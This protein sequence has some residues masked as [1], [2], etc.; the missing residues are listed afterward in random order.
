MAFGRLLVPVF[1]VVAGMGVVNAPR[2]SV[3]WTHAVADC[4]VSRTEAVGDHAVVF[5]QAFRVAREQGPL[6]YGMREYQ[7]WQSDQG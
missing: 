3:P 1:F 5:G 7:V 2:G 4:N 6:L